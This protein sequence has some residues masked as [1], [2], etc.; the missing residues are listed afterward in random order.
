[1]QVARLAAAN[2]MHALSLRAVREALKAGPPVVAMTMRPATS[3]MT[4]RISPAGGEAADPVDIQVGNRLNELERL[5]EQHR[6]PPG[7]VYKVLRE[8]VLPSARPTDVF[9]YLSPFVPQFVGQVPPQSRSV[10]LQLVLWTVRAGQADDLRRRIE[11][12]KQNQAARGPA[13]TLLALL[14]S[15]DGKSETVKLVLDAMGARL[16]R[17]T[18][19]T[20]AELACHAALPALADPAAAETA[21]AVLAT[22]IQN[23]RSGPLQ[24]EE[25]IGSLI[26]TL[27]RYQFEHGHAAE[28]RKTLQEYQAA[29]EPLWARFTGDYPL[30]LR[31]QAL[32]VV[33]SEYLRVGLW[34]DSLAVLGDF[35]DT[36]DYRA[37]TPVVSGSLAALGRQLV[38]QPAVERYALLRD[39]TMPT[40][41][42]KSVRLLVSF[43]PGDEPPAVFKVKP[44]PASWAGGLAS[45]A[46]LLIDAAREA[47]QLDA[48]AEAVRPL[49]DQKVENARALLVLVERA[50][51]RGAEAAPIAREV[52]KG[53]RDKWPAPTEADPQPIAAARQ[54][55]IA[56]DR[57]D[58]LVALACLG[59]PALAVLGETMVRDLITHARRSRSLVYEAFLY[60]ELAAAQATRERSSPERTRDGGLAF[61]HAANS[62]EYAGNDD[63]KVTPWW[64]A[65]AGY[66]RSLSGPTQNLL[67]FDYPLAGSFTF[68]VDATNSGWAEWWA[69]SLPASRAGARS[70]SGERSTG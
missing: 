52:S 42:R 16:K 38:T 68:S 45:S 1:M 55:A 9:L 2:D 60:R 18:L 69:C 32:A 34:A 47:G 27:A 46:A 48:L 51:G 11:E 13:E 43:V 59:D 26:R 61:W 28:G 22:A 23:L 14:A 25:P 21:A 20:S 31:K 33:L 57:N 36:A 7:K 64:V 50:R 63:G 8:V 4:V 6:A 40:A 44:L 56:I 30:F 41:S 24:S 12:R 10:G 58:L 62:G 15:A 29:L 67:L 35:A 37:G 3:S 19:Q 66:V 54:P 5:W 53:I 70:F 65:H 39:W 49:A 17:D